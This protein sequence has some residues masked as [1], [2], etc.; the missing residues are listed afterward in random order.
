MASGRS[1]RSAAV[2]RRIRKPASISA[3]WRR[4]SSMRRSRWLVPYSMTSRAWGSRGQPSRRTGPPRCEE[5][6]GPVG[7]AVLPREA[8]TEDGFPSGIPPV[9]PG[10]PAGALHDQ[11]PC[12]THCPERQAPRRREDHDRHRPECDRQVSPENRGHSRPDESR[13]GAPRAPDGIALRTSRERS[14]RWGSDRCQCPST[15]PPSV[16]QR[17]RSGAG[18]GSN[19]E[20][21]TRA[22]GRVRASSTA[23]RRVA[24]RI[25]R[26]ANAGSAPPG[27]PR[28]GRTAAWSARAEF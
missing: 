8:A 28:R 3:F 18:A 23:R 20:S 19:R 6:P 26:E 22:P 11:V 12:A 25:C 14:L 13:G 10:H 9:R 4:L 2:K 5:G 21:A 1:L 17:L 24:A 27:A 16:R 7:G 15:M